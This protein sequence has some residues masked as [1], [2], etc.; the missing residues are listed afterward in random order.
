MRPSIIVREARE[1]RMKKRETKNQRKS[2]TAF[3]KPWGCWANQSL[4]GAL[5]S[6]HG[7]LPGEAGHEGKLGKSCW[8]ATSCAGKCF[9]RYSARCVVVSLGLRRV[10]GAAIHEEELDTKL[11]P[12]GTSGFPLAPLHWF[13]LTT[14]SSRE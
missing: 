3:R 13:P 7:Q 10:S 9:C 11:G 12:V 1:V 2:P 6:G 5:G 4:Q 14:E 8:K